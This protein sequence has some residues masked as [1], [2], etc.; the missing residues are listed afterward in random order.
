MSHFIWQFAY[1]LQFPLLFGTIVVAVIGYYV[2][3]D[4][5]RNMNGV[6]KASSD[7]AIL[8]FRIW[9][10]AN[11]MGIMAIL[12][13]LAWAVPKPDFDKQTIIQ[14]KDRLVRVHSYTPIYKS[15]KIVYKTPSYETAFEACRASMTNNRRDYMINVEGA[16]QCHKQAEEAS[17]P[18]YRTITRTIHEPSNYWDIFKKCNDEYDIKPSEQGWNERRLARIQACGTVA[19]LASHGG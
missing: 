19:Q 10:A 9:T 8:E 18:P 3:R 15:E 6:S 12:A 16:A 5:R 4:A 7:W 1:N 13:I 17:L 2:I 11:V 14:Y